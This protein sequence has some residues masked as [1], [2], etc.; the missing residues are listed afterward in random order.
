[1]TFQGIGPWDFARYRSV[2][3]QTEGVMG[4][5]RPEWFSR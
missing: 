1:M 4:Q 3:C 2:G 5:C